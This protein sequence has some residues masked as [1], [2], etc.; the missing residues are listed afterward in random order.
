MLRKL[1]Q[2]FRSCV[3][4]MRV[5]PPAAYSYF[6]LWTCAF[7][8]LMT[9]ARQA[10][11]GFT[12]PDSVSTLSYSGQFLVLSDRTPRPAP[13]PD[14]ATNKEL[15][16]LDAMLLTVSSE[17]IKQEL[18]RE[19]G[20]SG[21]WGGKIVLVLRHVSEPSEDAILVSERFRDRW[22]YK[23][24]L[25]DIM[26]RTA[27]VRTMAQVLLLELANRDARP[28]S[29]EIPRWLV[30]G[31]TGQLL[32]TSAA[33]II[34]PAPRTAPTG[35]RL[36]STFKDAR[37][38]SPL[39]RAHRLMGS[40]P[41]LTFEQLSWPSEDQLAGGR[42]EFYRCNAQL[43]VSELLGL[44]LGQR[45]FLTMLDELPNHYNWQFA[46]LHAFHPYFER[47]LDVEKWWALRTVSFTGRDLAQTWPLEESL[48]KLGQT[49]HATIEIR[50]GSTAP[51]QMTEVSLQ[52]IIREWD[53]GRQSET[54]Q[55]KVRELEQVRLRVVPEVALLID[56][57][58][59]VL[60]SYLQK[61]EK[62]ES[63]FRFFS[64][65]NLDDLAARTIEQLNNL[66]AKRAALVPPT[67]RIAAEV[68]TAPR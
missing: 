19:V 52:T 49:L 5:L 38:E 13:A 53:Q 39:E 35:I 42:G 8:F 61:F 11:A 12:L 40:Q 23:L 25:P 15:A 68:S 48:A 4:R 1:F 63:L 10:G 67:S 33:E 64:K 41:P 32:A 6:A 55:E 30:E 31:L 46:F 27:Y 59:Q 18:W 37:R 43:F 45:C 26:D 2:T 47:S 34:L 62:S 20:A 28:R 17:R 29:A 24:T 65:R 44:S 60:G 14:L 21:P 56:S 7:L 36:A 22:Q 54:L 66:D 3:G 58:R 9:S 16:W 50:A 57:Y 51:S